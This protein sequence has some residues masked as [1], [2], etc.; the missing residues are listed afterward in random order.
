M[1]DLETVEDSI[2]DILQEKNI[3]TY[4]F[5]VVGTGPG[6]KPD[7]IGNPHETNVNIARQY[8]EEFKIDF[9]LAYSYG[10]LVLNDLLDDLPEC[11]K[12][13]ILLDP[14]T[15]IC[16]GVPVP[17][18]DKKTITQQQVLDQ[19]EWFGANIKKEILQDYLFKLNNGND[20]VTAAYTAQH[21]RNNYLN[22]ISVENITKLLSFKLQTFFTS[23]SVDAVR[24]K[25]PHKFYPDAS[26]WILLERARYQLADDIKLAI[27][28][29]IEQGTPNA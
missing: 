10:A 15:K 18:G 25:L 7:T 1:F 11:V 6:D 21:V 5:N 2:A 4:T 26:H 19:L 29:W 27:V 23:S 14:Y 24:S 12:G 13:I 3:E 9:V 28:Q 16:P 17:T 22:F 20:L 8:I